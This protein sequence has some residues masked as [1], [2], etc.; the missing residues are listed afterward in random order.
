MVCSRDTARDKVRGSD[1]VLTII[2]K[3]NLIDRD[4]KPWSDLQ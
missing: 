4:R 3:Y 1:E 2:G